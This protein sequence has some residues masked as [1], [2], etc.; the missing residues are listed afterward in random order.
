MRQ[1]LLSPRAAPR[2]PSEPAMPARQGSPNHR[3][4]TILAVL[5][6]AVSAPHLECSAAQKLPSYQSHA[7]LLKATARGKEL[8]LDDK[9][10][11]GASARA[12][13]VHQQLKYAIEYLELEHY[14]DFSCG[15]N[16]REAI[17]L[18]PNSSL[19]RYFYGLC[20]LGDGQR[21]QAVEQLGLAAEIDVRLQSLVADVLSAAT[22]DKSRRNGRARREAEVPATEESRSARSANTSAPG[23]PT[24]AV[25]AAELVTGDYLC[26]HTFPFGGI[27]TW[28]AITIRGDGKYTQAGHSG[29]YSYD[30]HS[31]KL[32]WLTGPLKDSVF[33]TEYHPKGN[34]S[35]IVVQAG[36]QRSRVWWTC[37]HS[38]R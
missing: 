32:A 27:M 29:H 35:T 21:A 1:A 20:L 22:A 3:G 33:V 15:R 13:G 6:L 30:P 10:P 5:A 37:G 12:I 26:S 17:M 18:D 34:D 7:H 28:D 4:R 23:M 36:D 8:Y 11:L 24:R 25:A 9:P 2:G 19:A 14:D 31:R 38:S 16:A